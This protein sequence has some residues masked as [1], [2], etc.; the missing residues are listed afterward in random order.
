M[1]CNSINIDWWKYFALRHD[2]TF[3]TEVSNYSRSFG[4]RSR[5][6]SHGGDR[7]ARN[8]EEA[9]A[10]AKAHSPDAIIMDIQM[11]RMDGLTAIRLIRTD[12]QIAA[13][14]T[15]ALTALV[16]EGDRERCLEA[17]ANEYLTKPIM[18]QQ[19]NKAI[20]QILAQ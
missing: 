18:F 4:R 10:M 16:M 12:P 15:I 9:V 1:L 14:P 6:D 11:P 2:Q 20:Q 17:G 5:C 8:G 13:I 3:C 7:I 19:L